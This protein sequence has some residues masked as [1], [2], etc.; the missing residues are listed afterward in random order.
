V[1]AALGV[2]YR[3]FL[4]SRALHIRSRRP[5]SNDPDHEG[6]G[7]ILDA[8]VLNSLKREKDESEKGSF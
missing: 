2:D 4:R 7:E 3:I 1:H 6:D 8:D 5:P